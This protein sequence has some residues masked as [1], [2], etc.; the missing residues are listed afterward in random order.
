QRIH[1]G[2]LAAG[3]EVP[4]DVDRDLDRGMAE[5]VSDIGEADST[6]DQERGIG[7]AQGMG[8]ARAKPAT[9][10]ETMPDALEPV[11]IGRHFA[12]GG[13]AEPVFGAQGSTRHGR[14]GPSQLQPTPK[15][16]LE[17]LAHVDPP[18]LPAFRGIQEPAVP[19]APDPDRV[20]R[21]VDVTDAKAEGLPLSHA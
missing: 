17:L 21:Q 10:E 5:L 3:N 1:D 18:G 6:L 4:V 20:A 11:T 8:R 2:P 19:R 14:L 15:R 9:A 16:V 12:S 7:V 13:W